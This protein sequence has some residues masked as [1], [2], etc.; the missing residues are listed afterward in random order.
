MDPPNQEKHKAKKNIKESLSS[1]WLEHGTFGFLL[2]VEQSSH[3]EYETTD[4][5]SD[6]FCVRFISKV[7]LTR[8]LFSVRIAS[9]DRESEIL[10][11][12]LSHED[13]ACFGKEFE[14]MG[15]SGCS[16]NRSK[17]IAKRIG[18]HTE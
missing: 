9:G 16:W 8:S 4:L 15:R 14:F 2:T 12:K 18:N 5:I 10:T 6:E 17:K 7:E 1:P 3:T 13:C 11:A